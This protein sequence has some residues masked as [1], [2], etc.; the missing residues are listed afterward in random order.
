MDTLQIRLILPNDAM[1]R[2]V[3]QRLADHARIE[4]EPAQIMGLDTIILLVNIVP[5]LVGI[6]NMRAQTEAA[7]AQAEANIA[8]AQAQAEATRMA[9]LKLMLEIQQ[10]L[11]QQGQADSAKI[12]PPDGP[13]RPFA[14]AD[15]AFLRHLLGLPAA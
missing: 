13:L 4:R 12:G 6:L 8:V 7:Q 10:Q 3:E 9:T 1:A 15:E 5:T 2:Q 11:R 14:E